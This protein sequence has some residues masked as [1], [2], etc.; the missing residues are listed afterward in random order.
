MKKMIIVDIGV[1]YNMF[2]LKCK[3][4]LSPDDKVQI[5]HTIKDGGAKWTL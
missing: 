3:S 2:V 5:L 4:A 1:T